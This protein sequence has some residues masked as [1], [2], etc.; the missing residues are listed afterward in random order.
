[1]R[2]PEVEGWEVGGVCAVARLAVWRR[3]AREAD[4]VWENFI[5]GDWADL[6]ATVSILDRTRLKLSS[7]TC[8]YFLYMQGTAGSLSRFPHLERHCGVNGSGS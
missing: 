3:R 1:M 8:M 4:V 5:L 2:L 6:I 7:N